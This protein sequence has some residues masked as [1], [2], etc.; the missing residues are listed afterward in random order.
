M[1]FVK[2]HK[3]DELPSELKNYIQF[4]EKETGVPVTYISVGPNR[5]QIII[6]R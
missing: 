3:F 6:R 4:I 5:E 2:T 1:I